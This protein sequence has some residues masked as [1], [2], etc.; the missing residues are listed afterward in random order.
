MGAEVET[1]VLQEVQIAL[2]PLV[3]QSPASLFVRDD[4]ASLLLD[5]VG[6]LATMVDPVQCCQADEEL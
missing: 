3:V 6:I 4:L 1:S 2:G 5:L